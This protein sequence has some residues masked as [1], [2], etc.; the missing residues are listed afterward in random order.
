MND[1]FH[2]NKM[3]F[4]V[5]C[6]AMLLIFILVFGDA[7]SSAVKD[8]AGHP[9][10]SAGQK[11]YGKMMP[12]AYGK[13]GLGKNLICNRISPAAPV[14]GV[15]LMTFEVHGYEDL[16][17][18][19]GQ[20]LV[21]IGSLVSSYF[22]IHPD[23]LNGYALYVV[24]SANPDGLANG[25]S[26]NGEGRCQISLGVNINRDFPYNFEVISDSRNHTL[27]QP[28]S[29]PESRALKSLVDSVKPAAVIDAHGWLDE[30]IG[31]KQVASA[32]QSGMGGM[33]IT[34]QL[35]FNSSMHGFF[36]AWAGTQGAKAM[37]LEYPP[38]AP[39]NE[40]LY[41]EGTE[42]GIENLTHMLAAGTK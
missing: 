14:K 23:L 12:L 27:S 32:F 3:L 4:A 15:I 5:L 24:P 9:A 31:D 16:Y 2:V 10:V 26:N 38:Q 34:R 39:K 6:L 29:A 8:H 11:P 21:D 35:D 13:S 40:S 17:P 42:L 36:S 30:L 41:A 33:G 7:P 37:L 1:I 20:A 18:K 22:S 28:L 25:I 19:D